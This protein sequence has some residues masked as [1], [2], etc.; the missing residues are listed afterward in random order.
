MVKVSCSNKL[1]AIKSNNFLLSFK[2]FLGICIPA[3]ISVFV[4]SMILVNNSHETNIDSLTNQ[5]IFEVQKIENSIE[6][7]LNER[8]LLIA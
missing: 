8:F 2:I 7:I 5:A 3:I 1:F 6:E 4:I